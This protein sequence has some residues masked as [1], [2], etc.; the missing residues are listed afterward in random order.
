[1]ELRR[2][3]AQKTFVSFPLVDATGFSLS[4]K[5]A[6]TATWVAWGDTAG[7]AAAGNPGFRALTNAFTELSNTAIY[8]GY[9]EAT[10]LPT[11]SP[12]VMIRFTVAGAA[13]QYLLINTASTYANVSGINGTAIAAPATAGYMPS[14]TWDQLQ[15]SHL[16]AGS[17][18]ERIGVIRRSTLQSGS[19]SYCTFDVGASAVNNFYQDR[20]GY[21]TGGTGAGQVFGISSYVGASKGASFY[22]TIATALDSTSIVDILPS[23]AFG[24][25]IPT[26]EEIVQ[27]TWATPSRTIT[28][29][30]ATFGAGALDDSAFT[31]GA[32]AMIANLAWATAAR[33]VTSS[34][35]IASGAI[36]DSSF[37]SG[38]K[39]MIAQQAW[40]TASKQIT[41]LSAAAVADA[42]TAVVA[43]LATDT[44]SEPAQGAP[45]AT[46]SL[47]AKI[48]YLYKFLR[49]RIT[50]TNTATKVFA[51]DAT[52]V[53]HKAAFSDDGTTADRQEFGSGP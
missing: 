7:W 28:G 48:G 4:G 24:P 33:T 3:P 38:A 20:M 19:A 44:Y 34:V 14:D 17:F 39:A 1:M 15:A 42:K 49:N 13:T 6:L 35:S 50:Q 27:L 25:T 37:T 31:N 2:P 8:G 12:Y 53:D 29:G 18:G 5:G 22:A 51:D 26:K 30:G 16:V 21:V 52:T 23:A 46:I 40:A 43:A 32:K 9:L 11:A 10:E 36:D 41:G 47:S 45:G